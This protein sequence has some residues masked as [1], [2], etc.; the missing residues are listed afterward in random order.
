MDTCGKSERKTS[1]AV[2]TDN[3]SL[4]SCEEGKDHPIPTSP[5]ALDPSSELNLI[6]LNYP[7]GNE[8]VGLPQYKVHVP[9]H[10]TCSSVFAIFLKVSKGKNFQL[11]EQSNLLATAVHKE[12]ISLRQLFTCCIAPISG[13]TR[14]VTAVRLHIGVNEK[15]CKRMVLVK[16]IYG[17]PETVL[18]FLNTFKAGLEEACRTSHSRSSSLRSLSDVRYEPLSP[19]KTLE[20]EDPSLTIKTESAYY[21]QFHK[22]LSSEAYSLGKRIALFV[23]SFNREFGDPEVGKDSLP[24]P[25]SSIVDGQSQGY[26]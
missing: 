14:G 21:Y 22:I 17:A 16:G 15:R 4:L 8:G 10:V 6:S 25:V 7:V 19:E 2:L 20:E 23:D 13:G 9:F 11:I 26:C 24:R 12:K 3:P 1:T 5:R 18:G